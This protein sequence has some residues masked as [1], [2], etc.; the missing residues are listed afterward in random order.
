MTPT[1]GSPGTISS[2]SDLS[3]ESRPDA[4]ELPADAVRTNAA[5]QLP[6]LPLE[7]HFRDR[8]VLI[9][10]ASRG[11]GFAL[12]RRL[13]M[14]GARTTLV[15]RNLEKLEA[16]K[17]SLLEQVPSADV[18]ISAVNVVDARAVHGLRA[19][20]ADRPLDVLV[21]NAGVSRPG[22][23]W[24]IPEND[25]ERQI[26][27]NFAGTVRV[28]RALLP[29]LEASRGHIVN[30]ASLS[31][32][33]ASVSH[34]AYCSSK[35]AQYGLSEVL[36]A[37]LRERGLRVSVVLPPETE[38]EMLNDE[39]PYLSRAA[40]ALQGSAGRLTADAVALATLR[41]VARGSY[42]IVPGAMARVTLTVARLAP[43]LVRAYSDWVVRR[44]DSR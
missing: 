36:R 30:V 23:F 29:L 14:L 2:R 31:S 25:F 19:S 3:L 39:R 21:N 18:A 8:H 11:I 5:S 17:R 9:T 27:V 38:T 20:L 37:E 44:L 1:N 16:A 43:G 42:E 34:S 4:P 41:G 24:E 22:R 15:A 33:V 12:A 26:D 6:S 7:R 35:F 13:V 28:T 40:L 32:V 10:G